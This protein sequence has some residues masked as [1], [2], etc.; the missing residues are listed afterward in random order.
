MPGMSLSFCIC[1]SWRASSPAAA[2]FAMLGRSCCDAVKSEA[3]VRE[4]FGRLWGKR[5]LGG[6]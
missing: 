5:R 3:A 6:S 2:D 4:P 1:L